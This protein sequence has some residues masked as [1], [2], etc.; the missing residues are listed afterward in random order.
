MRTIAFLPNLAVALALVALPGCAV[1]QKQARDDAM[2]AATPPVAPVAAPP[3]D[4]SIYHDAQNMELFADP[5]AHRMGDILTLVHVKERFVAA[6]DAS[7][8]D[9]GEGGRKPRLG[10]VHR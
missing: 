7:H 5:R 6:G 1:L 4:G 10:L 2:W 8:W 9:G 3:A